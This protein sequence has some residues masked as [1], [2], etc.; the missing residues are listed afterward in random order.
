MR[1]QL[2]RP[3]RRPRGRAQ[4][5][6]AGRRARLQPTAQP[7][8]HWHALLQAAPVLEQLTDE[9]APPFADDERTR[10]VATL[11]AQS[12]CAFRGFAERALTRERLERPV[13]GFNERERGEL[14]HHALEHIW[15]GCEARV[16]CCRSR[17]SAS[18]AAATRRS[19]A[20]SPR[21]AVVRDPGTA[22]AA[23]RTRAHARACSTNGWKWNGCA[24]PFEVEQL[25]QG[26]EIGSPC[27]PRIPVRHRSRRSARGRMRAS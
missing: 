4:P 7:R 6:V 23:A 24:Q 26:T 19:G 25:E 16:R 13:P 12:R 11:R 18:R 8:P 14:I 22:L 17:R 21:C 15:S 5:A 10:G 27:G 2:R 1:V 20:R 9:M 3:G